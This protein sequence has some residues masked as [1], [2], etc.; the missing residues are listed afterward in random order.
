MSLRRYQCIERA[1]LTLALQGEVQSGYPTDLPMLQAAFRQ[2]LPDIRGQEI[3]DALR[4]LHPKHVT[5]WKYNN[6]WINFVRGMTDNEFFYTNTFY[7]RRTPLTDPYVQNLE[8]QGAIEMNNEELKAK[9][10]SL[11]KYG[12][13]RV[14]NDLLSGAMQLIGD[15]SG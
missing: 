14:K 2:W 5:L 3:V 13:E 8:A 12:V 4:R 9:F 15:T 11:E 10:T 1:L 7:L 6:A